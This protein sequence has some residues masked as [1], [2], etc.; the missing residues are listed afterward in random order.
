VQFRAIVRRAGQDNMGVEFVELLPGSR[1]KLIDF[2]N[3]RSA[4]ASA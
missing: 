4:A 2:L 3:T 1:A